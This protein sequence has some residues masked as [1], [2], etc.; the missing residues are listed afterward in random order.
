MAIGA[1]VFNTLPGGRS[2]SYPRLPMPDTTL[3]LEKYTNEARTIVANAQ[4]LADELGHSE[5][6]PLHLL[7]RVL[8]YP[9]VQEVFR[10]SGADPAE[11]QTL[12]DASVRKLPKQPG[13]MAYVSNR[14]IDLLSRA[15]R[16]AQRDKADKVGLEHLLHALAQEIRGPAGEILSAQG[17]GPGG[18][19]SH[20]GA[21]KEVTAKPAGAVGSD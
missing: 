7:V 14:L 1:S 11:V 3:Q 15:E 18:F 5:V 9:G 10:R 21:L 8:E 6:T 2:R 19:R 13:G 4:Q 17:I 16:E 20:V 12:A